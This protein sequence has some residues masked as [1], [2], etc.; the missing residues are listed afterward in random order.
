M[1][2]ICYLFFSLYVPCRL[3]V[4][5]AW[6]QQVQPS[7]DMCITTLNSV[8]GQKP[9]IMHSRKCPACENAVLYKHGYPFMQR[10]NQRRQIFSCYIQNLCYIKFIFIVHVVYILQLHHVSPKTKSV[11]KTPIVDKSRFLKVR[12]ISFN[13]IKWLISKL[14]KKRETDQCTEVNFLHNRAPAS[15]ILSHSTYAAW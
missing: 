12:I 15:D 7:L 11:I 4:K 5:I 9:N 14:P 8:I 3:Q 1:K 13:P 6:G 2:K 10:M